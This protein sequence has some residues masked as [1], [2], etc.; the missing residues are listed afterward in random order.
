MLGI[1][2]EYLLH[3]YSER[4]WGAIIS[5]PATR[6]WWIFWRN[7]L[8]IFQRF[9]LISAGGLSLGRHNRHNLTAGQFG[10]SMVDIIVNIRIHSK[11]KVNKP[12]ITTTYIF[13]SSC[14]SICLSVYPSVCLSVYLFVCLSICL[15]VYL[16]TCIHT[17]GPCKY[18]H[19]PFPQNRQMVITIPVLPGVSRFGSTTFSNSAAGQDVVLFSSHKFCLSPESG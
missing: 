16:Y 15:S 11:L 14:L 17:S 4:M 18:R 6:K 19:I 7:R 10:L 2:W 9:R 3:V 12:G 1:S 5:T 8:A 13:D